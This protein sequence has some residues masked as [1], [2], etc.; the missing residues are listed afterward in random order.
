MYYVLPLIFRFIVIYHDNQKYFYI[1]A[2][3]RSKS[4]Q[5]LIEIAGFGWVALITKNW[6][7]INYPLRASLKIISEI[8]KI[9]D[10]L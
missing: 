8:F 6:A 7:F 3:G 10:V 2:N 1:R 4:Y 5:T 9:F